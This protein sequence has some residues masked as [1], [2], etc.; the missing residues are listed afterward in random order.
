M[1]KKSVDNLEAL[2]FGRSK[3]LEAFLL[4]ERNEDLAANY[5]FEHAGDGDS[6]LTFGFSG[7]NAQQDDEEED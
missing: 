2:G 5:L 1:K 3:A 7:P 6:G 4:C